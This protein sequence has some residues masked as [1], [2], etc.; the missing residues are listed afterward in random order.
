MRAP[1]TAAVAIAIVLALTGLASTPAVAAGSP[2]ISLPASPTGLK[3][4]VK[5]P[6]QLDPA[7]PY[8]PQA[9]C[10]P[11]DKIGA[12]KLRDL[13]LRTYGAGGRGNISR[14]CTEGVSEHSEG[15]AW[16]WMID[17]RSRTEKAA[18]ADFLSWITRDSG[19]NARRLGIMYVI[20]DAKIWAVYR[21]KEGW[22]PSSGHR[23]HV[24]I[25]LSWNGARAHTSFWT[26]KVSPTDLGPCARFTGNLAI[27]TNVPR[28]GSCPAPVAE[29]YATSRPDRVHGT[30]GADV[31]AAQILLGAS[32]T[33]RFD[34]ATLAAVRAFQKANDIVYTGALDGPTWSAL[35]PGSVTKRPTGSAYDVNRA[36]S[37]G[38]ERYR[39]ITI[40]PEDVSARVVVVQAALGLPAVQ[41]TGYFGPVTRAA[42]VAMQGRHGLQTDGVVD[43]AEW[44]AMGTVLK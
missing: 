42:V 41:R 21:A 1:R 43:R 6:P 27:L 8:L 24:H 15:R 30:T 4:P 29:L 28:T 33:G 9:G 12:A 40:R 10:W 22:R 25:S 26:G 16:D 32:R 39:S 5:L 34:G 7:S 31:R 36:I 18:A 20:H 13:V 11:V 37:Y 19:R 2:P 17:P 44:A 14:G 23:D 35:D 3:S 38:V